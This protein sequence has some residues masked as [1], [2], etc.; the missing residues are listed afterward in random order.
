MWVT[1]LGIRSR[2]CAGLDN[3]K[4][5]WHGE[6]CER[7]K[8]RMSGKSRKQKQLRR[9]KAGKVGLGQTVQVFKCQDEKY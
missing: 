3:N 7:R 9:G 2:N 5:G 8:K 1:V 6:Y 4:L